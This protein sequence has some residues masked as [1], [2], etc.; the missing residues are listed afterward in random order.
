MIREY[1]EEQEGE[2]LPDRTQMS[3][4]GYQGPVVPPGEIS[5]PVVP[6]EAE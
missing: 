5:I 4:I 3:L 2:P 1:I 6:P